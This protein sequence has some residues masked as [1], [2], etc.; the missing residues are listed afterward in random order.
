MCKHYPTVK[1]AMYVYLQIWI[2]GFLSPCERGLCASLKSSHCFDATSYQSTF[3]WMSGTKI[4]KESNTEVAL[5][6]LSGESSQVATLSHRREL[7]TSTCVSPCVSHAVLCG[8]PLPI[9]PTDPITNCFLTGR[10][11]PC[12]AEEAGA[13]LLLC[14]IWL[15][16]I[17]P[18]TREVC[19]CVSAC[20]CVRTQYTCVYNKCL[21]FD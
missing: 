3:D 19:L 18:Q 13:S 21:P 4:A 8:S 16:D 10:E 9:S 15:L 1:T 6:Q 2:R 17:L 7:F 20:M 5:S 11:L 12:S 14:V